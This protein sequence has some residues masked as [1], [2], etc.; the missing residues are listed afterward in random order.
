MKALAILTALLFLGSCAQKNAAPLSIEKEAQAPTEKT[1]EVT[2]VETVEDKQPVTIIEES[3]VEETDVLTE[4]KVNKVKENKPL[5]E[6]VYAESMEAA[7]EELLDEALIIEE[8]NIEKKPTVMFTSNTVTI[9][10]VEFSLSS[11]FMQQADK[12]TKEAKILCEMARLEN[13]YFKNNIDVTVKDVTR[14]LMGKYEYELFIKNLNRI[15]TLETIELKVDYLD[16]NNERLGGTQIIRSV[17]IEPGNHAKVEWGID[18]AFLEDGTR[19]CAFT[20]SD[21]KNNFEAFRIVV[22][23]NG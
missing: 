1:V 8:V 21:A 17:N 6:T 23:L 20:I 2:D 16:K 14:K 22:D 18:W 15:L 4:E 9:N 13:E 3:K 10:G 11:D 5:N 12:S 7:E 19:K